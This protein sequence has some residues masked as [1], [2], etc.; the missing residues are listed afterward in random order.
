MAP[1]LGHPLNLVCRLT[2]SFYDSVIDGP[3]SSLRSI[4]NQVSWVL[5][6]EDFSCLSMYMNYETTNYW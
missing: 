1:Y 5:L 4:L 2:L 3:D 6:V